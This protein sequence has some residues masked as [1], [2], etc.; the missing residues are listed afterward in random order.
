MASHNWSSEIAQYL[1]LG[2]DATSERGTLLAAIGGSVQAACE[3]FMGRALELATYTE[4]YDGN[5]KS[6]IFL[7][8]APVKSV[9]TLTVNG[10]AV[11]VGSLTAPTYP[12]ATV[13]IIPS[14]GLRYTDG[15]YF[16]AG[17]GNVIVTYVAGF[18][19]M[20]EDIRQAVVSWSALLFKDRDRSG[21][22]SE[23]VGGQSTSF[24]RDMPPFVRD[25]LVKWQRWGRPC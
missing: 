20:P 1:K 24:T 25:V 17:V 18:D 23:G 22:S 5:D 2:A 8:H 6:T 15:N 13:I 14:G 4:A 3:R 9:T 12:Q 7:R 19:T 16:P 10:A 21:L 11:T